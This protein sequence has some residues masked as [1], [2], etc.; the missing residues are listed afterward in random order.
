MEFQIFGPQNLILRGDFLENQV[1][2]AQKYHDPLR[3]NEGIVVFL[4]WRV[5]KL[6]STTYDQ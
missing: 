1:I 2:N 5:Q 3:E 4:K 6:S